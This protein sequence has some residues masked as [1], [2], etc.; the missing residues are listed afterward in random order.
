MKILTVAFLSVILIS[1]NSCRSFGKRIKGNGNM[2]TETRNVSSAD[3]LSVRGDFDVVLTKGETG[4]KVSADEN[5]MRYIRIEMD[6]NK[7]VIRSEDRI[8][9][10]SD[11]GITVN[12]STPEIKEAN[13]LGSGN[14]TSND[15]FVSG[16]KMSFKTTGSGNLTLA[17]NCPNIT[18]GITGSG[19]MNL[20]G[21][22]RILKVS[23]TGSGN[24]RGQDLKAED[25][26]V[27]IAGSGNATVFADVN[28]KG[29]ISGSGEIRYRGNAT[30][31]KRIS[32]SGSVSPIN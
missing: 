14:I 16:D 32:G 18:A 8:N 29:G 5:L 15:K 3:R 28:L 23:I 24:F 25:A 11:N 9:I 27:K 12:I 30:V 7:L 26:D 31:S 13:I 6:D 2:V 10:T 21:E 17:V 1:F 4:V 20:S 22:T 19:D